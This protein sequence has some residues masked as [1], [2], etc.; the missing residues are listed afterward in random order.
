MS[1]LVI[2]RKFRPQSF[3]DVSGQNQVTRTL[4]NSILRDRVAHAYLFAGPRGVGKTSIARIFAKA[5]NCKLGPTPTPCGECSNCTEIT[6]GSN[7]AVREI[8]GASHNSVDNVRDLIESFRALPAPGSRYKVYIIDEVHMFSTAAFNAL[9]KS[10]EEPPPNTV[11]ILATTEAHKIPE[12]VISRCQRHD[13]R[14]LG[15]R[16]IEDR[17][18]RIVEAEA[19]T[20]EPE[21]LRMI[22]RLGD[23]SM[24]DAQSLLERV[25]AFSEGIITAANASMVLGTVERTILARLSQAILAREAGQALEI[26]SEVFTKGVDPGLFLREFATH[27]RELMIARFGGEK[28]LVALGLSDVDR[29]ELVRQGGSVSEH[30]LQDLAQLSR[31][32][33]DSALRSAYPKYALE[34]LV[35]RMSTKE[36]VATVA[37]VLA[38]VRAQMSGAGVT[39]PVSSVG[40]SSGVGASPRPQAPRA[41]APSAPSAASPAIAQSTSAVSTGLITNG[42]QAESRREADS[43]AKDSAGKAPLSAGTDARALDWV[44]FVRTASETSSRIVAE[45]LKRISVK[46]FAL[47]EGGQLGVLEASGPEFSVASL[48]NAESKK[49]LEGALALFSNVAAWQIKFVSS[50]VSAGSLSE[51]SPGSLFHQEEAKRQLTRAEK[52]ADISNHPKVKSLQRI[53]PGTQIETIKIREE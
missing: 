25:N 3:E 17:L 47:K 29:V 2:A 24:R 48:N 49:K 30:D 7:L 36:P 52:Q 33:C 44:Q 38:A 16:D 19:I 42:A 43:S 34:A 21:A 40:A 15:Q 4:A 22:A 23:G 12:T 6:Q 9:L 51:P 27:F 46:T 31:E 10:L 8:D 14:A 28:A 32:G 11:F 53:F 18:Q 37:E 45:H 41:P 1:Y 13:F 20:I 35:V 39:A 50:G 26:V 5:L